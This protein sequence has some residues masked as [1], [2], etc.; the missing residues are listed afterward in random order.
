MFTL[1]QIL[2]YIVVLVEESILMTGDFRGAHITAFYCARWN[3][4]WYY[5]FHR[6]QWVNWMLEE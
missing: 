5:C 3:H 1:N 6:K 2:K 4:P